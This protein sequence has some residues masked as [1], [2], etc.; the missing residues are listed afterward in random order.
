MKL[1]GQK[2]VKDFLEKIHTKGKVPDALL[3]FGPPGVGK[4]TASLEFSKGLLCLENTAWGCGECR[5]CR[6]LESIGEQI[7]SGNW[8]K[9][10]NYEERA[11]KRVFLYLSGEHP[12]FAY[13]PPSGNSLK[14]DQIRALREFAYVKPALS[15][16]KVIIVDDI[17]TMTKEASNALLKV[18]EEPPAG[19]HFILI[20]TGIEQ[21]LPTII[22]RAQR[23]EFSPLEEESFY[24]LL[25]KED[26]KLYELSVGSLSTAI[27]LEEKRELFHLTKD[28]LSRDPLKVFRVSQSVEKLEDED[29][30]LFLDLLEEELKKHFINKG[31]NYDKFEMSLRRIE[32]LRSGIGRGLR[33]SVG[34]LSLY[35]LWR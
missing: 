24:K 12:D 30:A 3:F 34:L 5:S 19:T 9:L 6:E 1:L 8:D 4:T 10:S 25:G 2:R 35:R 27:R 28:F 15:H 17:H 11:G 31:L 33:F 16:K 14:I 20:S 13:V 21:V 32:E 23:V 26:R 7:L 29:K 22:S 18:L